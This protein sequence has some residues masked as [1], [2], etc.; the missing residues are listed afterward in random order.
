MKLDL[1]LFSGEQ[2]RI[3]PKKLPANAATIARNCAF[4]SGSLAAA[5]GVG[6]NV[7]QQMPGSG[8]SLYRHPY[9]GNFR[10]F[11]GDV[12]LVRGPIANDAWQRVYWTD[13]DYPKYSTSENPNGSY[14]LGIPAPIVAPIAEGPAGEPPSGSVEIETAYVV[15]YVSA[16]GEEGPPSPV[17]NFTTRWDG[18][19]VTL[20][21][22]PGMPSG[23]YNIAYVRLYRVESGTFNA[24]ATLTVNTTNYTDNVDTDELLAPLPSE[25]WSQPV[26]T[27]T[28]L[29]YIGNG[30]LAG[31]FGNTVC[32]SEPYYPHAWPTSYQLAFPDDVVGIGVSA[33]GIVVATKGKPWILAGSHPAGMQQM[34]LDTPAACVAKRSLVD[35]GEFIVYASNEG[36]IAAAGTNAKNITMAAMTADDF[37]ALNPESFKAYRMDNLYFALYEGGAF[38]FSPEEGFKFMPG[39]TAD[40]AFY[41]VVENALY[42][43]DGA[44]AVKKFGAGG[45]LQFLW[46]SKV[47]VL[48]PLGMLTCGRID[49]DGP[50][51][52]TLSVDGADSVQQVSDKE[53]FRLPPGRYRELAVT[54][55]GSSTVHSVTLATSPGEL[56]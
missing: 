20:T 30:V 45:P 26:E 48:P 3:D 38:T 54:L 11:S 25:L 49:A 51:T 56:S 35:M 22:F 14:R 6:S 50:V 13:G 8:D 31:F 36:L 4:S 46:R 32:F 18:A 41:D 34:Q 53:P 16:Y 12:D 17:S 28:G 10:V 37:K 33:A 55:S 5:A 42:L 29:T 43:L 27:M 52:F 1:S 44:G 24:V 21:S 47:F 7:V 2:P 9:A 39:I 19:F 40:A 23:E 15:T